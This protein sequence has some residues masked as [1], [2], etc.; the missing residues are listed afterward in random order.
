MGIYGFPKPT[1]TPVLGRGS[2]AQSAASVSAF[3]L[4]VFRRKTSAAGNRRE[5]A[6]DSDRYGR[7]RHGVR[8]RCTARALTPGRPNPPHLNRS[9]VPPFPRSPERSLQSRVASRTTGSFAAHSID[10][11]PHCGDRLF[12]VTSEP[13]KFLPLAVIGSSPDRCPEGPCTAGHSG[14]QQVRRVRSVGR[15][16][17]RR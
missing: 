1:Q 3:G 9:L 7:N 4:S 2:I 11:P 16:A 8:E 5:K 15:D 6:V 10:A 17:G 14:Q 13:M 12:R